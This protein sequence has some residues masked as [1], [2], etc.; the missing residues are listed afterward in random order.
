[1]NSIRKKKTKKCKIGYNLQIL[2]C[3]QTAGLYTF[4]P[5]VPQTIFFYYTKQSSHYCQPTIHTIYLENGGKKQQ[6][7]KGTYHM[8]NILTLDV[9]V[10]KCINTSKCYI[11]PYF[12]ENNLTT[13][14]DEGRSKSENKKRK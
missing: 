6:N 10:D 14:A 4:R 13:V 3:I 2:A 7:Q 5:I 11:R 8:R 1:M 12:I 9:M